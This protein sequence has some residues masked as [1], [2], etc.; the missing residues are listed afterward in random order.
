MS[1][2]DHAKSRTQLCKEIEELR[3]RQSVLKEIVTRQRVELE[4]LQDG[5]RQ[6]EM[7]MSDS[8]LGFAGLAS[9]ATEAL[10]V[11]S[12]SG[13]TSSAREALPVASSSGLASTARRH[14][15]PPDLYGETAQILQGVQAYRNTAGQGLATS[16]QIHLAPNDE[17]AGLR[18]AGSLLPLRSVRELQ[19]ALAAQ[20]AERE[21]WNKERARLE[22]AVRDLKERNSD[23]SRNGVV[24]EP[25][26][27]ADKLRAEINQLQQE[28][29]ASRSNWQHSERALAVA[30]EGAES[31]E[32]EL[33]N[34][35]AQLQQAKRRLAT[36]EEAKRA[37]EEQLV[38]SIAAMEA[39]QDQLREARRERAEL[40]RS[41]KESRQSL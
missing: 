29:A 6:L 37:Q 20:A 15:S 24:D 13:L 36:D 38:Q 11:A 33:Q 25:R 8:A 23:L 35:A 27:E 12:S 32:K 4:D 26:V 2:G 22:T 34:A 9:T 21:T 10:P 39:L 14:S 30:R 19:D 17:T 31:S 1:Y 7:V 3:K 18:R 41:L 5:N 28:T 40:Q 16:S